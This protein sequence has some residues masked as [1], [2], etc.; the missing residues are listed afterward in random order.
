MHMLARTALLMWNVVET[1]LSGL[2]VPHHAPLHL[3]H[4]HTI[5]IVARTA[6]VA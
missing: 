6:N 2:A 4:R 1:L 3:V 5:P